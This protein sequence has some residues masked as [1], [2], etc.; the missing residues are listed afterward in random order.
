MYL[1]KRWI[2]GAAGAIS[3]ISTLQFGFAPEALG[4]GHDAPSPGSTISKTNQKS[5][6]KSDSK[7]TAAK[8]ESKTV[9]GIPPAE[10]KVAPQASP[11]SSSVLK[12]VVIPVKV[13]KPSAANSTAKNAN[14]SDADETL[15]PSS[16]TAKNGPVEM[17]GEVV[18]A[19][20]W[21]SGVMGP[22]RGE[23]HHKCALRC[24]LGGVSAGIVDDNDNLYIAAKS[25]AYTGC[26][27]QL[28]PF[29]SH[30]VKVKGWI[31]ERGGCHI[32]KINE[33][34]D[35]GPAEKFNRKK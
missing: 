23:E 28:S 24:I 32:L 5:A 30:R 4:E 10:T 13:K 11:K 7:S 14:E 17:E 2:M 34:T 21:S 16:K 12:P 33:V 18:D 15:K 31:A 35:L 19:W 9:W 25:K 3:C 1:N 6:A 20:C 26:L 27:Q 8:S 22:G 29:I